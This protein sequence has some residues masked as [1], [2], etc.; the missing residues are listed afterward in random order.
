MARP[1]I[2][3]RG[4]EPQFTVTLVPYPGSFAVILRGNDDLQ[5][6]IVSTVDWSRLGTR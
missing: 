1:T 4:D 3:Q 6:R 2:S 5:K